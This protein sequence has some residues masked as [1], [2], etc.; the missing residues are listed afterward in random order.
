MLIIYLVYPSLSHPH[1]RL[2]HTTLDLKVPSLKFTIKVSLPLL[3]SRHLNAAKQQLS[4]IPFAHT[5]PAWL[6]SRSLTRNTLFRTLSVLA[7]RFPTFVLT[8]A[9]LPGARWGREELSFPCAG[10]AKV[11]AT[12]NMT[13]GGGRSEEPGRTHVADHLSLSEQDS[14]H[15][16]FLDGA[17]SPCEA[18]DENSTEGAEA[19]QG[20]VLRG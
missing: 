7:D 4:P 12:E 1:V 20:L 5:N 14:I 17:F 11:L 19:F 18:N 8:R 9:R 15:G 6:P 10:K 16:Y 13:E 3:V 2:S